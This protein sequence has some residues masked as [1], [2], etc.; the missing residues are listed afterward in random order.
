MTYD[1]ISVETS[2]D[3]AV[4]R[5]NRPETLNAVTASMLDELD[6]AFTEAAAR[7]RA[8]VLTASGKAFS[9]GAD[10]AEASAAAPAADLDAGLLLETH[11]NPLVLKLREL[12]VPWISAVRGAVAGV[13]CSI[14]LS[15]D[16]II[17]SQTAYFFQ[18]FSRLGLVPDGGASWLASRALSRPRAMEFLLLAEKL[19]AEKALSWGLVNQVVTDDELDNAAQA[20]AGRLARGPTQAYRLIRELAWTAADGDF[21]AVLSAEREAQREAG[22]TKDVAEGVAA[23]LQKRAPEFTGA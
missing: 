21:Q 8:I 10:M 1:T 9:A 2:D 17:A 18:A 6:A 4:I 20:L 5:L 14:A 12:K 13:G 22:R 19:P 15:A 11:V 16:L 23:F 3:V 7:A